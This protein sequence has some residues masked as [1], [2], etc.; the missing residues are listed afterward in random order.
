MGDRNLKWGTDLIG[1]GFE[2]GIK[3]ETGRENI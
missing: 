1:E 2:F 3:T